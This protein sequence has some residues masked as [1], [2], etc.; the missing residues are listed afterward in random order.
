MVLILRK[1]AIW[2]AT[3]IAIGAF[4]CLSVVTA[5]HAELVDRIVAVVNDDIILQSE[6]D[7]MLRVIKLSL[8]QQGYSQ[9]QVEQILKDQRSRLISQL[10]DDKLKDQQVRRYN[11]E[12]DDKEVEQTIDRIQQVNNASDEELLR[13]LELSGTTY[14]QY[15]QQIREKMLRSRLVAREV[16]SK[17]VVTDADV[18][19]YYNAH[20]AQY[21]GL[22]KY[23]L[24]HILMRVAPYDGAR[25]RT[26]IHKQMEALYERLQNG[27]AFD[28]LAALY[29]NANTA[30][31]GGK[32]GVFSEKS[33]TDQVRQALA[34]LGEKQFTHVLDTEQGYQIFYIEKIIGSGGKSL[35]E[36]TAEIQEKL[37]ADIVDR[38]FQAWLEKLRKKSHIQI[39]E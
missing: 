39:I 4:F 32:L 24:R 11:I 3:A 36:A 19:A 13:A 17:I 37:Y 25:K 9:I 35:E 12:I 31:Q 1:T 27:E 15:V 7:Q 2:S 5:A 6:V 22:V 8:E 33:L 18:A 20:K 14:A 23:D 29:S 10:I 21:G 30:P 26:Q 38:Q 16:S 34:G 28:K